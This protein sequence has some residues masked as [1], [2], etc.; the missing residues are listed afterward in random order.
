VAITEVQAWVQLRLRLTLPRV[1]I[2]D[3]LMIEELLKASCFIH[4]KKDKVLLLLAGSQLG[5][6]AITAERRHG[7]LSE[8]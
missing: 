1:L 4:S 5:A 6:L 7:E 3:T 2:W 8:I